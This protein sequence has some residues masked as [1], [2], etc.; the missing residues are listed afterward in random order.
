MGEV[1]IGLNIDEMTEI[2]RALDFRSDYFDDKDTKK[3]KYLDD[4][5][6][7]MRQ[8]CNLIGK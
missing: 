3:A 2:I 4:L 1:L 6:E 5:S 8:Y 7:K